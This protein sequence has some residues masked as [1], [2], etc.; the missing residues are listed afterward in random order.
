VVSFAARHLGDTTTADAAHEES[1]HMLIG[2]LNSD[3]V[4]QD[5]VVCCAI[6][7]L[8]VYEQLSGTSAV[9][10]LAR[11]L[12]LG[13]SGNADLSSRQLYEQGVIKKDT[14][15]GVVLFFARCRARH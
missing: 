13:L 3:T 6:V 12:T 7:I 10:S 8:R 15:P 14:L 1:I 2:L 5:E 4:A 9:P 11:L